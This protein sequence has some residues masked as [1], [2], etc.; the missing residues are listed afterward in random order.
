MK[1]VAMF[2][3]LVLVTVFTSCQKENVLSEQEKIAATLTGAKAWD[4]PIVIVDGVDYSELYEGFSITFL[5][6]TYT[7]TAGGPVWKSA[8]TWDFV[9]EGASLINLDGEREVEIT[10]GS[11]DVIELTFE[12]EQDT[13]GFERS[14]SVKGKQKFK[15]KKRK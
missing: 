1:T 8:G 11:P 5:A 7:T 2:T 12:W 14:G 6:D 13:F 4:T 3:C 9:E 10:L 15:L